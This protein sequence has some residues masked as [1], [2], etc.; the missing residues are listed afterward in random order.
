MKSC[1]LLSQDRWDI[2]RNDTEYTHTNNINE[3][4]VDIRQQCGFI[5]PGQNTRIQESHENYFYNSATKE[6]I[7]LANS[8]L[9]EKY[10]YEKITK[11]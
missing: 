4:T 10:Q 11:M 8:K 6:K 9:R 7:K 3:M 5:R 2:I 1:F